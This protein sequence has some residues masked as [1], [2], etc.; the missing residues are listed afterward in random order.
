MEL[1]AASVLV[2]TTSLLFSN[3]GR[4]ISQHG[5]FHL[6]TPKTMIPILT[7]SFGGILVGL[8]T[9]H[10]GSVRKGFALIFGILLSGF[11]QAGSHGISSA[12]IVGGLVAA[13][14]LW[15]HS[16]SSSLAMPKLANK[17]S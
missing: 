15:M 4:Q 3:D 5:F 14:S 10:A 16:C 6:W 7:N 8:V 9:K 2:L 17:Q 12:Q 11:I 1:T 13:T